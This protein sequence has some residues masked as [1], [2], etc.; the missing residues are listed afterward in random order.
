MNHAACVARLLRACRHP[1]V[2]ADASRIVSSFSFAGRSDGTR[3]DDCVRRVSLASLGGVA[4]GSLGVGCG[5]RL[6]A[7][8][9]ARIHSGAASVGS[10]GS[11]NCCRTDCGVGGRSFV[12]VIWINFRLGPAWSRRNAREA[13]TEHDDRNAGDLQCVHVLFTLGRDSARA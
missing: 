7:G 5:L 11:G 1:E 2:R 9:R 8:A 12:V 13:E 10:D 3:S 6:S 4:A